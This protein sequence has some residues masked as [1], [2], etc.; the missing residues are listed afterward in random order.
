MSCTSWREMTC[1]STY[2][3]A[4][5]TAS[6]ARGREVDAEGLTKASIH[7]PKLTDAIRTFEGL[8]PHRPARTGSQGL[9]DRHF[10]VASVLFALSAEAIQA[11]FHGL[12]IGVGIECR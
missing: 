1:T 9:P 8:T 10:D 11:P 6:R 12:Q 2:F 4:M 5:S 7:W 3:C